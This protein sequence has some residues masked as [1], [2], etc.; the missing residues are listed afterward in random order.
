ML[1]TFIVEKIV[2]MFETTRYIWGSLIDSQWSG[3]ETNDSS[4]SLFI[5]MI[6]YGNIS[7]ILPPK[8]IYIGPLI[9]N[10]DYKG[11]KGDSINT[12]RWRYNK[13]IFIAD[14]GNQD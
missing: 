3:T 5:A 12:L 11:L 10:R 14:A 8:C 13:Y 7:T 6:G 9:C 4:D 2:P 1:A